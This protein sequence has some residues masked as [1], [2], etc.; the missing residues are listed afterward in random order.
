MVRCSLL[1][2]LKAKKKEGVA[3]GK[4]LDDNLRTSK[5]PSILSLP[6]Q[7]PPPIDHHISSISSDSIDSVVPP[8]EVVK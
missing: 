5:T 4:V 1:F 7:P 2:S 3:L 6:H 8:R